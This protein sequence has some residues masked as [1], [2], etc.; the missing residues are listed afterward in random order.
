MQEID[1]FSFGPFNKFG[2]DKNVCLTISYSFIPV[3]I[4]T[5]VVAIVF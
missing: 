1:I 2:L 4:S 3:L 5:V